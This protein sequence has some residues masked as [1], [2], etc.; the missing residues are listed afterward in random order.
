MPASH[1]EVLSTNSCSQ[2][3][4]LSEVSFGIKESYDNN[5]F[6]SGVDSKFL[7]AAYVVPPGSVS[8]L[9]DEGSWITALSPRIGVNCAPLLSDQ[10][11]FKTLS[12]V[13]APDLVM[14]H[15]QRSEDYNAHRLLTAINGATETV[16]FNAENNFLF[17]DGG[18][19]AP[20]YPDSLYSSFVVSAARERREQIQE[21]GNISIQIGHGKWFARPVAS[22][23]Y[24]DFMTE[25][26]NPASFPGYQ[27]YVDRLDV[28]GGADFGF[29]ITTNVAITVGYRGGAQSQQTFTY[30]P[31]NSSDDYQRLLFGVEG[32]PWQWLEMKIQGGPDFRDYADSAPMKDRQ[33]VKYYGEA[34]LTATFTSADRMVFKC[35]Q[36]QWLSSSGKVPYYE[37]LCDLSYHHQFTQKIGWDLGGRLL[38][39]DFTSGNLTAC[40]RKDLQYTAVTGLG[41]APNAHLNFN[42]CYT[43]DWGRNALDGVVNAETRE[44]DH[45]LVSLVA[46][47]KF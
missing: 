3:T 2:M 33:P 12:L 31:Y 32:K 45:Q 16:S 40:R 24:F 10:N 43:F 47:W 29:R 8:A 15:D 39:W 14:Y 19:L 42:L 5:V 23:L 35:K 21:R 27:N 6:L 11:F 26:L 34:A 20:V 1:A 44:F 9:K 17:I 37:N 46:K 36:W 30:S 25:Q 28:N 7:P 22:L 4:W 41:Y 18:Q 13:Y 38:A